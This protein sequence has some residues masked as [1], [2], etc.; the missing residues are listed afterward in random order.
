MQSTIPRFNAQRMLRDYVTRLY[1]PA[2]TQRRKLEA[3]GAELARHLAH[4]KQKV[5]QAWPGVT[6][7]LMFQPPAHLYHDDTIQL[8]VRANLNGLDAADVKLECLFGRAATDGDIE[9]AQV[10]E[11]VAVGREGD[12]T[13][14][15]I[16]LAPEIA[17]LQYYKL[18]MYPFSDALSH[19]FE[20]GCMIWV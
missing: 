16:D 11:L 5:R 13:E 4:W 9:V 10:G 18:R 15:Q 14:F 20:L 12:C 2:Q 7:Q 17:G 6:M 8:R 19:P 3:N 1:H